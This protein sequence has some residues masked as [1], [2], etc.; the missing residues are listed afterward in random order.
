MIKIHMQFVWM[1]Y[2]GYFCDKIFIIKVLLLLLQFHSIV[3]SDKL[4]LTWQS[5]LSLSYSKSAKSR[6]K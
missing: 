6:V 2:L 3:S 5:F 1:K 4:V